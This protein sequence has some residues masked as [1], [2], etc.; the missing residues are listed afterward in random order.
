MLANSIY[1]TITTLVK[2]LILVIFLLAYN[3]SAT[4]E[5]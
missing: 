5:G 1:F 4:D 2:F 3:L